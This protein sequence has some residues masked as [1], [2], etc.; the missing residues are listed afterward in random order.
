MKKE[1][2]MDVGTGCDTIEWEVPFCFEGCKVC[3]VFENNESD[4]LF[5]EITMAEDNRLHIA[6][7]EN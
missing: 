7:E 2:R 5:G 4:D 6:L 3:I 1:V